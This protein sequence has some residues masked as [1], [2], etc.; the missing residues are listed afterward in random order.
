MKKTLASI[1]L[2]L[3]VSA[4][5][6]QNSFTLSISPSATT[7]N[8]VT[9]VLNGSVDG[10][11]FT[12]FIPLIDTAPV[13]ATSTFDFTTNVDPSGF[14]YGLFGSYGETGVTLGVNSAVA[15]TLLGQ[16]W[17]SIITNP[18]FTEEAVRAALDSSDFGTQLLF[19]Q[20]LSDLN[21]TVNGQSTSILSNL[22]SDVALLNFS[23]ASGNG[24][25]TIE[26]VPE[27]MTMTLLA[28]GLATLARRRRRA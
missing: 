1:S 17:S 10:S 23:N 22:G 5:F 18:I 20:Y 2:L 24:S 12:G 7:V 27:P 6:A 3:V 26:S 14:R 13:G 28:A 16:S 19:S 21:F 4:A 8:N 15:S 25:A 9:A 11:S